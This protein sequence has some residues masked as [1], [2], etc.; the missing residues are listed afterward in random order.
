MYT[1]VGLTVSIYSET[2]NFKIPAHETTFFQNPL[3]LQWSFLLNS[4]PEAIKL[5][6]ITLA[7]EGGSRDCCCQMHF[8]M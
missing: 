4:R 5:E 3:D 2:T 7:L 6:G 8:K 1:F